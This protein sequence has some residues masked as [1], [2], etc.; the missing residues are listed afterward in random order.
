M[1]KQY[2]SKSESFNLGVHENVIELV[3]DENNRPHEAVTDPALVIEFRP[4]IREGNSYA[5]AVATRHF[6]PNSGWRFGNSD[7]RSGHAIMGALPTQHPQPMYNSGDN[8]LEGMTV[9][10]DPTIHFGFF[11]TAWIGDEKRRADAEKA[12]DEHGLKGIEYIEITSAALVP[13]WPTYD[14]IGQGATMKIPATVKDLGLDP[15]H[16]MEYEA[17]T[18]NRQGVIE[19]L[20]KLIEVE[21]EAAEDEAS[22]SRTL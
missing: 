6:F 5:R 10:Y 13:P 14:A 12:L 16:V 4:L 18:K 7:E 9:A 2:A 3:Y 11:D 8:R 20:G 1:P 22:L 21:A 19:A 17:A 15:T